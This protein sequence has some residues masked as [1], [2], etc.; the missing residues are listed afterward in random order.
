MLIT[1][2]TL[3]INRKIA[4]RNIRRMVEKFNARNV[5]LRPHFKTHQSL[6]VGQWFREQG[7]RSITVTSLDMAIRFAEDGWRD[8]LIAMPFNPNETRAINRFPIST[9]LHLLVDHP[10]TVRQTAAELKRPVEIWI[11]IDTGYGRC[12]LDASSLDEIHQ[13]AREISSVN[14]FSLRGILTHAGNT[15]HASGKTDITRIHE[16]SL[17]RLMKVRD[18][19]ESVGFPGL[20]IS[21]GDT[22]A[23]SQADTFSGISEVRCGNF[24]FYDVM[25]ARLGSCGIDDIAIRLLCPVIGAYPSRGEVVVRGGKVHLS[26]D[27]IMDTDGSPLFGLVAPC[28]KENGWLPPLTGARVRSLSQE[29]GIIQVGREQAGNLK[30]GDCLG[31]LPVHSCLAADLATEIRTVDGDFLDPPRNK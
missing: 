29:H 21:I 2:P 26:G 12:G 10:H 3:L 15:Y 23:C 31:I 11:K 14:Y 22:P 9:R 5:R 24:V 4:V 6:A 8:I 13:L 20:E 7:L 27:S 17:V 18:F 28:L 30:P 16:Q 1:K 19:L 25:Q